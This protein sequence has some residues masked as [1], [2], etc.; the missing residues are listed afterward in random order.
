MRYHFTTFLMFIL[1]I[2]GLSSLA[3]PLAGMVQ[4]DR[5]GAEMDSHQST[6][7]QTARA[8]AD[9][10][11]Q[12]QATTMVVDPSPVSRT[13]TSSIVCIEVDEKNIV[14]EVFDGKRP[15][16]VYFY[17]ESSKLCKVQAPVIERA[18]R[19]HGADIKFV[20]LAVDKCPALAADFNITDVPA[21]AVR[22]PGS[23]DVLVARGFLDVDAVPQFIEAGLKP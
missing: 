19:K 21:H 1:L 9:S 23:D 17:S 15:V 14:Q 2:S 16:F 11:N 10:P 7:Q 20:K 3:L 4:E 18:A 12:V 5:C 8:A 22:R 13:T 6:L